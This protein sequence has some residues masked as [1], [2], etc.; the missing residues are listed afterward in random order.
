MLPKGSRSRA[1]S[2]GR[3]SP[4]TLPSSALIGGVLAVLAITGCQGTGWQDGVDSAEAW[5]EA[6]ARWSERRDP[7]AWRAWMA[8]DP[9]SSEGRE[10]RRLLAESHAL[11]R[12]G[13]RRVEEGDPDARRSFDEAVVLAPMDP[14][15][16]LPLA[17][18]FRAQADLYPENPHLFIRAAVYY[19]KFLL[20]APD[21]D[22][23]P[24]ARHE[25]EELD[26]GSS[27]WL[28]TLG[29]DGGTVDPGATRGS[30]APWLAIASLVL[31]LIA[32]VLLLVRPRRG[33]RSLEEL[34]EA[35]PELHPAI[36]YLAVS[37]THLTL[38]TK[39]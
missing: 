22:Q 15:L 30:A 1:L 23:A 11:Y 24:A 34:A 8:I 20:L 38:P 10:A 14:R 9:A 36:A 2:S 7:L 25:L 19:R 18:A 27:E 33:M 31:A 35:R 12:E 29:P 26:P 3:M 39:A 17:R 32:L 5:S 28:E 37:Y 16:Y 21:D 6:Q 4:R 13:I